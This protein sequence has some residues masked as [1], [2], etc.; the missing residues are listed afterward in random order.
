MINMAIEQRSTSRLSK[1]HP[2]THSGNPRQRTPQLKFSNL[3]DR[4]LFNR[5]IQSA[6]LAER[7]QNPTFKNRS[8]VNTNRYADELT[9]R[10]FQELEQLVGFKP[11]EDQSKADKIGAILGTVWEVQVRVA[12]TLKSGPKK[13]NELITLCHNIQSQMRDAEDFQIDTESMPVSKKIKKILKAS[14]PKQTELTHRSFAGNIPSS[15]EKIGIDYP[16]FSSKHKK[17]D[18]RLHKR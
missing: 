2:E 18:P 10:L 14:L 3:K 1:S 12:Q 15:I 8:K 13:Q 17:P 9:H 7:Q 5:L 4:L 6:N 16:I 11:Q